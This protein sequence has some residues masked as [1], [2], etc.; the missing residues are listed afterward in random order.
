MP[1][2]KRVTTLAFRRALAMVVLLSA[3][4]TAIQIAEYR[5]AVPRNLGFFCDMD[6]CVGR[7]PS[8]FLTYVT[9]WWAVPT[10]VTVGLVVAAVVGTTRAAR[11]EPSSRGFWGGLLL[12]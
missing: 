7:P 6:A 11:P 5:E 12:R 1:G 8:F 4:L 9:P 3:A 2:V 10:A